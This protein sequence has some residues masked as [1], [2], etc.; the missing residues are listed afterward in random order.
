MKVWPKYQLFLIMVLLISKQVFFSVSYKAVTF[1][2]LPLCWT[3]ERSEMGMGIPPS[4]NTWDLALLP[5]YSNFSWMVD[6][7]VSVA[8]LIKIFL[9]WLIVSFCGR[10]SS[11]LSLPQRSDVDFIIFLLITRLCLYRST[12]YFVRC[13]LGSSFF[14]QCEN[15]I[16]LIRALNY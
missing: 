11:P 4:W 8:Q 13:I 9:K 15:F 7:S 1:S 2:W 3:G 12:D 16:V 6:D 10:A 14:I 5:R